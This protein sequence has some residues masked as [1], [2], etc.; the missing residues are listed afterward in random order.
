M[1][2]EFRRSFKLKAKRQFKP[3]S[4]QHHFGS[5]SKISIAHLTAS[6]IWSKHNRALSWYNSWLALQFVNLPSDLFGIF[7]PP[8]ENCDEENESED[9][10]QPFVSTFLRI[11]DLITSS[12]S[13]TIDQI[14]ALLKDEGLLR[15]DGTEGD[16]DER[17]YHY[18]RYFV[19]CVLG[20]Q[21]MLFTPT[22]KGSSNGILGAETP[23]LA[24]DETD[25]CCGYTHMSLQQDRRGCSN[26]PLSE[27]LMGFGVLLPSKSLC[28]DED[29]NIQHAF[30]KQTEV[31][32]RTFNAYSLSA[33]AGLRIK[34]VDA[35]ACHLE[36]NST[37]KEI[38]LFRFPS[39]CQSLLLEYTKGR[40]R[41]VIHACATTSSSR[42]YWA[43]EEE[44]NQLLV[45][46][47]LSYRLLFGQTRKS[48]S[49][50]RSSLNPF[51]KNH[52]VKK[53]AYDVNVRDPIL[54][55]LCGTKD[56]FDSILSGLVEKDLYHLPR[57]F[58]I[59]RY[60]I[61]VLQRYLS[62]TTPRT[63]LQLW[64]DNRDSAGWLTFWAV[65]AFGVF[66]SVMAFLQVVLQFVQI[67]QQ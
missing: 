40:R 16:N 9:Y 51:I 55:A 29:P 54:S 34:W 64:R 57:D 28:L 22:P 61:S 62:I 26:E 47:L 36:F 65:I 23:Q 32:A 5:K 39:F 38:S 46:I 53:V 67:I 35:L 4:K 52:F 25:G 24:I 15:A 49:L 19:F 3:H 21:T 33:V 43:T 63:W 41:N 20:W 50:F 6:G 14:I 37:T 42:S 8:K 13:I 1:T 12:D 17:N 58:P 10:W 60:R 30:H 7:P 48:R 27:F 2:S 59:L 18:A 31:H 11:E 56:S 45:E 66:G 44:V